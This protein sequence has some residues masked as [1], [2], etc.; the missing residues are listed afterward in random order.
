ME[1]VRKA[2]V[3]LVAVA[4]HANGRATFGPVSSGKW[5]WLLQGA[6]RAGLGVV[7]FIEGTS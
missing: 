6:N 4:E 7:V 1:L 2:R 3:F 5:E